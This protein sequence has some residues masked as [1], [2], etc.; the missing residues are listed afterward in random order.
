IYSD[1]YSALQWYLR[2]GGKNKSAIK[3]IMELWLPM[4]APFTP[5]IAEELWQALGKKGFVSTAGWPEA[6]ETK[7][8]AKAEQAEEQ[9]AKTSNDIRN[10]LK[11][12]NTAPKKICIYAIP[13]EL[14]SYKSAEEFYS[15]EFSAEVKAFA[16]NDKNKYDPEGKASK[17]KPGKPGI[18]LE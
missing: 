12:I 2:R 8:N 1:L 4:M 18:Y 7:T 13:N 17:A 15:Q 9:I 3:Q 14:E 11:I 6:D 10:I 16:V 5:H